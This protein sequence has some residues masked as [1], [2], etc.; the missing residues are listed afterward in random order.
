MYGLIINPHQLPVG[1]IAQLAEHCTGGVE[2]RVQVRWWQSKIKSEGLGKKLDIPFFIN[3]ATLILK[4][5]EHVA[6]MQTLN[7][8]IPSDLIAKF[9]SAH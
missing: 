9:Q 3:C 6:A 5:L 2:I 1:L 4:M 7:H 8:L